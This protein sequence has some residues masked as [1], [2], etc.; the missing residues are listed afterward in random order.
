MVDEDL[1]ELE[2][3]LKRAQ[4]DEEY[5]KDNKNYLEEAKR[6]Y[7]EILKR[8][9]QV[10]T[11]LD[12]LLRRINSCDQCRKG[13]ESDIFK[14]SIMEAL[15]KYV[16][17][18]DPT[19]PDY[20]Q[21]VDNLEYSMLILLTKPELSALYTKYTTIL[22]KLQENLHNYSSLE[23][24][25]IYRE[26]AGYV[27]VAIRSR[28]EDPERYSKDIKAAIKSIIENS[29]RSQIEDSKRYE[30]EFEKYMQVDKL[31]DE[32]YRKWRVLT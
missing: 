1:S 25:E 18:I 4:I 9:L 14:A 11:A 29:I 12:I 3:M 17:E 28:L 24:N 32:L 20:K 26:A 16:E 19:K 27:K 7:D 22:R 31:L 6:L 2:K 10:E 15:R 13:K 30:E 5:R 8:G 23:E 21:K